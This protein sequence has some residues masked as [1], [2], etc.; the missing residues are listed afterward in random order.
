MWCATRDLRHSFVCPYIRTLLG[1]NVRT[2][3]TVYSFLRSF[4]RSFVPSLFVRLVKP[5]RSL[6]RSF[7]RN[8]P[9][10]RASLI[11]SFFTRVQA[12]LAGSQATNYSFKSDSLQNRKWVCKQ[13]QKK[14]EAEGLALEKCLK[15]RCF[16]LFPLILDYISDVNKKIRLS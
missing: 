8:H 11:S 14:R 1:S 9:G 12:L 13:R 4:S 2:S 5:I 15:R 6:I 10:S 7:V 3:Y 16:A